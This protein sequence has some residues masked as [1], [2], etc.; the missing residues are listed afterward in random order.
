MDR[1]ARQAR[2]ER[3][4]GAERRGQMKWV[5][6]IGLAA[7]VVAGL[8]I[9]ASRVRTAPEREYT[10]ANGLSLG[11]PNAPVQMTEFADFQCPHC[12]NVYLGAED[13][14]IQTYV[15][16]GKVYFT[17]RPVGFLG[18]ESDGSAAAAFC[19]AEQNAFWPYHDILFANFS[20]SNG[21]GYAAG[22]LESMAETVGL[23]VPA[24]KQC[25]ADGIGE[26]GVLSAEDEA[27][28]LGI[29]GTPAFVINGTIVGGSRTFAQ[30]AEVIDAALAASG[31]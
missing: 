17:Y 14:L 31:N 13:E 5:L 1:S 22:R 10:Q 26:A 21:G 30:L 20:H 12:Y 6:Y 9:F 19:A 7:V 15:E 27:R 11:D 8:L 25:L 23:D 16:T 3:R 24:F 18:P 2:L 28:G 29:N 4:R